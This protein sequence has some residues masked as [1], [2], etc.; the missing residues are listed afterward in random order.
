MKTI[1]IP[2]FTEPFSSISHILAAFIFLVA[3][4]VLIVRQ[5]RMGHGII[6]LSVFIFSVI[7]L[8]SLSGTYHLLDNGSTGRYV[9]RR[10]DHAGI[11]FLIAGTFT[12]IHVNLFRG[13]GRWGVLA[14]IW[15]LAICGITLKSIFFNEIPEW[16]GLSFY[17]GLGWF[18]LLTAYLLQRRYGFRFILP[19]LYGALAY[20]LGALSGFMH[21]VYIFPGVIGAHEVF[22][23]SVIIG[24]AFFWSFI[25]RINGQDL[26]KR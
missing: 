1:S 22:H 25:A 13:F 17:L 26:E 6:S 18:G 11:F 20:T 24:I 2:G 19:M 10:L 3:G 12:P 23:L 16:L 8:L 7:T 9:L 5:R 15:I 21:S 4:I 14:I